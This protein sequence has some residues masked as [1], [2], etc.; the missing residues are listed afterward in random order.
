MILLRWLKHGSEILRKSNYV[1]EVPFGVWYLVA[2]QVSNEN[3]AYDVSWHGIF[4]YFKN[5]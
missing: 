5:G 1:E 3:T 4:I 2:M